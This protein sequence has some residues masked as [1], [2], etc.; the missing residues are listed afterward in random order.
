MIWWHDVKQ[1]YVVEDDDDELYVVT[2]LSIRMDDVAHPFHV[3]RLFCLSNES[4]QGLTVMTAAN[5]AD[6]SFSL[7]WKPDEVL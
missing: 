4:I 1:G 2:D 7:T 6:R 3:V 5:V